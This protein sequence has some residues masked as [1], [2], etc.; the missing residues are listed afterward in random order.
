M[1][2]KHIAIW[3]LLLAITGLCAYWHIKENRQLAEQWHK[4]FATESADWLTRFAWMRTV[5]LLFALICLIAIIIIFDWQLSSARQTL[6]AV[7]QANN[8]LGKKV[9]SLEE[10]ARQA[11][12]VIQEPVPQAQPVTPP[13]SSNVQTLRD[14]YNPEETASGNQA[15][16]DSIKKRYEDILVTYFF[17]KKCGKANPGDYHIITSALSQEMASVNAPGRM[18]NDILTSAQGS[19]KEMYEQSSCGEAEALYSQYSSYISGLSQNFM[20]R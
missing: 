4:N 7:T 12:M 20:A 11:A 14:V 17:L 19:Y 6:A 16:M 1:G 9:A 2:D 5:Q 10:A 13:V 18:Q 15:A 8:D 3:L